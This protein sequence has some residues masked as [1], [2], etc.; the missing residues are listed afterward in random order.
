M[1]V[2]SEERTGVWRWF[3]LFILFLNF[4]IESRCALMLVIKMNVQQTKPNKYNDHMES[5]VYNFEWDFIQLCLFFC[6]FSLLID[7]S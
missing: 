7:K 2:G 3:V 1:L 4:F 5:F 6:A